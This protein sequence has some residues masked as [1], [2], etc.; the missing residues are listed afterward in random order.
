[1]TSISKC[2][3]IV[4]FDPM[5]SSL[6][7]SPMILALLMHHVCEGH[8]CSSP[9]GERTC[10]KTSEVAERDVVDEVDACK[11]KCNKDFVGAHCSK[12]LGLLLIWTR[13]SLS[14]PGW[15]KNGCKV[16]CYY[17]L[18]G[19]PKYYVGPQAMSNVSFTRTAVLQ[20]ILCSVR[21]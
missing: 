17:L 13:S 14:T 5:I 19:P 2:T 11:A 4:M 18:V 16:G 9:Y 3:L 10:H 12:G 15:A 7:A 1:M 20:L 8:V 6:C 21:V